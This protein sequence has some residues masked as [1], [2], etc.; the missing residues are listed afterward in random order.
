VSPRP[1]EDLSRAQVSARI[2]TLRMAVDALWG[3]AQ[4][5]GAEPFDTL[6]R[7]TVELTRLEGL[8]RNMDRLAKEPGTPV[9]VPLRMVAQ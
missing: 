1:V 7:A 8:L 3:Q 9:P 5:D 2:H 4:A 6:S